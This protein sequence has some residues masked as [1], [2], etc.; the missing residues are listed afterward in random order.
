MR[1]LTALLLV[2]ATAAAQ[3]PLD[4]G[5]GDDEPS[6][7]QPAQP[8]PP[9]PPPEQPPVIYVPIPPP[10]VAP[11]GYVPVEPRPRRSGVTFRLDAGGVY[12]YALK[13]SFG[14]GAL[15]IFLG[16]EGKSFGVGGI[17]DLELGGSRAG[18]FYTVMDIG[19]QIYAK[20][21]ESIRLGFGP[22]FGFMAIQRATNPDPFEDLS[23]FLIGLNADLSID[24]MKGRRSALILFGR[25]RYDFI[26]TGPVSPYSHG[27]SGVVGIGARM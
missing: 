23:A 20:L 3:Q 21:G 2:A 4:P 6:P 26:D 11:P 27:G 1:L 10:I 19:F 22:Q 13:D 18:L 24:L 5:Y 25:V 17:F 14:A 8:L 9:Y 12:R 16:G 15:R 7:R